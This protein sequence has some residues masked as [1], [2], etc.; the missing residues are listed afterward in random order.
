MSH[1]PIHPVVTVNNIKNFIPLIL[2]S[3][4]EH[5]NTWAELFIL[6]RKAYDVLD[7]LK[8]RVTATSSSTETAKDK[9][10]EQPPKHAY[11]ESWERID[12]IVL[13]WI[14]ATISQDLMHTIMITNT[15]AYDAW[16]RLKNLFLDNQAARTITI[17]NKI[18]N[19]RLEQFSTMTEYCQHMKLLHDQL[20]SLGS[21]VSENQLVLQILTGLTDQ[22]ENISLILPQTQPLPDFF[23]TRS[24][25]CQVEERKNAQAKLSA[26]SAGTALHASTDQPAR[27]Q[28]DTRTYIWFDNSSERGRG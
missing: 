8:P 23:K 24:R 18:F 20:T 13:Q 7:H 17:Q 12:S 19:A 16:C 21:T 5:Y 2:D 3:Q 14:Y 10:K 9:D 15:T 25:L 4:T 26:Q 1:T 11:L 22:Y 6:H 28:T 27:A